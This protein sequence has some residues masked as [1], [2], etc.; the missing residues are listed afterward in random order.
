MGQKLSF[1]TAFV[2]SFSLL[3]VALFVALTSLLT[4]LSS[5]FPSGIVFSTFLWLVLPPQ[6]SIGISAIIAADTTIGLYAWNVRNVG[7]ASS[8]G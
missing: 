6:V 2:A 7:L 1:A 5:A 4:S 3:T 8:A